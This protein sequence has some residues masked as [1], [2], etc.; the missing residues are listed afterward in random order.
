MSLTLC[1][2][3]TL[4]GLKFKEL[5]ED[6][7]GGHKMIHYIKGLLEDE[8]HRKVKKAHKE[9]LLTDCLS[10]VVYLVHRLLLIFL[11]LRLKKGGVTKAHS[12]PFEPVS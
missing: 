6:A 8:S 1:D 5:L 2:T 12:D 10:C 7:A 4:M 9:R 11:L 3:L